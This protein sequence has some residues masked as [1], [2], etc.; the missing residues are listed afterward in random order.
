MTHND[1]NLI[2]DFVN[3]ILEFIKKYDLMK[4]SDKTVKKINL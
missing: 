2:Y 4:D 1:F 3:P